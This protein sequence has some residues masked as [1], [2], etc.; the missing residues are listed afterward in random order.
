MDRLQ[1]AFLF[2]PIINVIVLLIKFRK[3]DFGW[4]RKIFF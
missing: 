2:S 3:K 1:Y 4:F